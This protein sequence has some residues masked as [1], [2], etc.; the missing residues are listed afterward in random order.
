M[1]KILILMFLAIVLI[2]GVMGNNAVISKTT[3]GADNQKIVSYYTANIQG[4]IQ[5]GDYVICNDCNDYK[6]IS[7]YSCNYDK[8]AQFVKN[9]DLV[10]IDT[11]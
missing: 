6:C 7:L 10:K 3:F 2:V 11:Y 4:G 5:C 9:Y 1:K 8:L